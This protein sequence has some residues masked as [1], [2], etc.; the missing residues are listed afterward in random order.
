MSEKYLQAARRDAHVFFADVAGDNGPHVFAGMI[1]E[2]VLAGPFLGH[3]V[4]IALH[5][6]GLARARLAVNH[7][8]RVESLSEIRNA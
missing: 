1:A 4:L 6:V 3:H 5:G 7:D 2:V 8:C